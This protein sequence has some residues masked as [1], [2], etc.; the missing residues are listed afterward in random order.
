MIGNVS[1]WTEDCRNGTYEGAPT[2]G[3]A[4]LTGDCARRA[5]RGASWVRNPRSA[6]SAN[7]NRDDVG[8][9]NDNN[10]FRLASTPATA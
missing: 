4:W 2:D 9:R 6:R 3:S 5:F 1:E 7:R 8:N 10:G